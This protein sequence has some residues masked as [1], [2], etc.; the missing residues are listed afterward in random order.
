M[1]KLHPLLSITCVSLIS[2]PA[3]AIDN[4]RCRYCEAPGEGHP[5]MRVKGNFIGTFQAANDSR[6]DNEGTAAFNL[7]AV[8]RKGDGLWK[9]YIQGNSSPRTDGVSSMLAEANANAGTATD[10]DGKG[11]LQVS[12]LLYS[13]YFGENRIALGLIDP[14]CTLDASKVAN[15]ETSQFLSNTFVNNPTIA[16][17]DYALGS[18]MH[19]ANTQNSTGVNLVLTSSNGLAD[20]PNHSYS[21]LVDVGASGKGVFFGSELFWRDALAIWRV[22]V[23]TS[24]G[25]NSVLGNPNETEANYGAYLTTDHVYNNMTFNLRL[26]VSN[27]KVSAAAAYI[28][29]AMEIPLDRHTLGAALGQTQVSDDA[30]PDTGNTSQAEV[31][32]RFALAEH[33]HI[34]PDVQY[35]INSGFDSSGSEFDTHVMVYSVRAGYT[36]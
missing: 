18:C 17:P 14:A 20:N 4:L 2:F 28:G 36:F 34:T 5:P 6:I 15:D 23:W 25:A 26:G 13:H 12:E 10:A 30:G 35:I 7:L 21:E 32:M 11:R 8:L 31:Y 33:L 3:L 22:G 24:T 1:R 29:L 27:Q 19:F 16:F 9:A